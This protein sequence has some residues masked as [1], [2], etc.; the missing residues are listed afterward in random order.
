MKLTKRILTSNAV[1]NLICRLAHVYIWCVYRTTKWEIRGQEN[2]D[3]FFDKKK[4]VIIAFWH[5][6]LLMISPFRPKNAQ[7]NVLISTHNDGELIARVMRH[8]GFGLVRGSSKKDGAAAFRSVLKTLRK[9]EMVAITP[10]GPR[11]PRMRISGEIIKIAQMSA[12]PIIPMTFS[13]SKCKIFG[14]WDRFMLAKPFGKGIFTY[15]EPL[16]VA[17]DLSDDELQNLSNKLENYMNEITRQA[18]EEM[19]VQPVIPA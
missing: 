5:G 8:F 6:R 11:G 15:G 18:D 9:N 1:Q 7:I 17:K 14:S 4:P 19:G 2:F 3:K 13:V 12:V 10:D 16:N